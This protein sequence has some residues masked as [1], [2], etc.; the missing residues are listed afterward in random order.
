MSK[1]LEKAIS[2]IENT[3]KKTALKEDGIPRY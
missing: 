2:T 1:L 3:I